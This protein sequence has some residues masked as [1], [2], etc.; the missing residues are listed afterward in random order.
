MRKMERS[1][2]DTKVQDWLNRV[3]L[4]GFED[5][6]PNRLSG[7]QQQRVALARVLA[8]EPDILLLD[9]PLSNLDA[10]LRT[11]MRIE[12][13]RI[14][15]DLG[16]TTIYVTHDQLEALSMADRIALLNQGVI[17][18][19]DSPEELYYN[20]ASPF[21]ADFMGYENEFRA[22]VTSI[23]GDEIDLEVEGTNLSGRR[24]G[25]KP[26]GPGETVRVFFHPEIPS[27]SRKKRNEPN[28]IPFAVGFTSFQGH[29]NQYLLKTPIGEF[30]ISS[31]EGVIEPSRM[32]EGFLSIT[33]K[34][35]LVY[36]GE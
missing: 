15:N 27:I 14:Q 1:K 33:P 31:E 7:G 3:G 26:P 9:E 21:V 17:E 20:P 13:Q 34:N 16:I 6:T 23:E 8:V 25:E 18:Q 2:I 32:E 30:K 29:Q 24:L 36:A 35:L 22:Q 19:L 11:E 4:S 10:K 5:R 12:L 28:V